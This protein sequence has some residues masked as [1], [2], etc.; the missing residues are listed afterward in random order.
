MTQKPPAPP[1]RIPLSLLHSILVGL[2]TATERSIGTLG[3]AHDV[4]FNDTYSLLMEVA[5]AHPEERVGNWLANEIVK[6]ENCGR[7]G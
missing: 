7:D 1:G 5:Y 4:K 6:L 2:L 3:E